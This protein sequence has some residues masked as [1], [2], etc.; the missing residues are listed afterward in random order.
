M[1]RARRGDRCVLVRGVV[2]TLMVLA[3]E[4]PMCDTVRMGG[5]GLLVS[6]GASADTT[7]QAVALMSVS[8]HG[9]MLSA[10]MV[11][12]EYGGASA[13]WSNEVTDLK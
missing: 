10:S 7:L 5:E 1:T 4:V 13:R 12:V 11:S 6:T 9:P 2:S 8:G 3:C